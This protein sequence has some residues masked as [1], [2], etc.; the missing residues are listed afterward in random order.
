MKITN[1]VCGVLAVALL[2][3]C[4]GCTPS[5]AAANSSSSTIS[6]DQSMRDEFEACF[7]ATKDNNAD[8]LYI[9]MVSDKIDEDGF[10][11][12]PIDQDTTFISHDTSISKMEDLKPGMMFRAIVPDSYKDLIYPGLLSTAIEVETWG[13]YNEELYQ[14]GLDKFNDWQ[15]EE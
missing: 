15:N 6:L 9:Y 1:L 14:T 3:I 10:F 8:V 11:G 2:A 5:E 12:L 13:K 4:A 7:I